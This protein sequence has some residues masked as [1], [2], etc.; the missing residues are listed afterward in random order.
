MLYYFL[1]LPVSLIFQ[2]IC[3]NDY[4]CLSLPVPLS[5]W[6][7]SVVPFNA[8]YSKYSPHEFF[9]MLPTCLFFNPVNLVKIYFSMKSTLWKA[10]SNH[11]KLK[12]NLS[13]I[14]TFLHLYMEF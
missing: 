14:F 12:H 1:S 4:K 2:S 7:I 3:N 13:S 11:L 10:N 9:S 6:P 8:K 5:C